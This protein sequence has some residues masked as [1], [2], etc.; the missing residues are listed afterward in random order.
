MSY[1]IEYRRRVYYE[2]DGQSSERN[3]ILLLE[4]GDN[5]VRDS[6]SGRRSR[7]WCFQA[8]GWN[9]SI[10]QDICKRAGYCEGGSLQPGGKWMSPENYLK[11]YR[12][13]IK[14]AKPFSEFI[15]EFH[16]REFVVTVLKGKERSDYENELLEALKKDSAFTMKEHSWNDK[17][18]DMRFTIDIN[19]ESDLRKFLSYKGLDR[20]S[21]PTI[22]IKEDTNYVYE[23]AKVETVEI[24]T[25]SNL[26][27]FAIS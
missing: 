1:S 6:D 17:E 5:N 9:Y 22:Y 4:E 8:Y 12:R 15:K 26:N 3:Y 18:V 21:H 13:E 2:E 25:N 7:D 24:T 10:I 23:K 27:A 20:W 19:S 16:T 11:R 14:N